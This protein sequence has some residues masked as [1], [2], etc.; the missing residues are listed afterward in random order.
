V[1]Q[2]LRWAL[3]EGVLVRDENDKVPT[4]RSSEKEG[5]SLYEFYTQ[6][7]EARNLEPVPANRFTSRL[8][9]LGLPLSRPKGV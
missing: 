6:Y 7:A 5:K 1:F 2:F 3:R 4:T 9:E 8:R